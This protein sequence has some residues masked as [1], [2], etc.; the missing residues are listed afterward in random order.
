MSACKA[1]DKAQEFVMAADGVLTSV[2]SPA[3]ALG[4][5]GGTSLVL[6][7]KAHGLK[8]T[9]AANGNLRFEGGCAPG[10][11]CGSGNST[12]LDA[13]C[14]NTKSGDCLGSIELFACC[15]PASHCACNQEWKVT[16][17]LGAPAKAERTVTVTN[18]AAGPGKP[19]CHRAQGCLAVCA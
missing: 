10:G 18:G 17:V 12:C 1:G 6:T 3:L 2:V 8:F 15:N 4:T 19:D 11:A 5:T 13:K 7:A 16:P 9:A 14:G